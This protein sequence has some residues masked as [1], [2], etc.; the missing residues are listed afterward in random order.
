MRIGKRPVA[1]LFV[2]LCTMS[3]AVTAAAQRSPTA[4]A[5]MELRNAH[6]A[7]TS[8]VR[9]SSQRTSLTG[10]DRALTKLEDRW[11]QANGPE[12]DSGYVAVLRFNATL[13]RRA[14]V[15]PDSGQVILQYVEE[16]LTYKAAEI[17][18]GLGWTVPS[19]RNG[20][21]ITVKVKRNG[22]I[23]G[24]YLVRANPR[25]W[26][27][28]NPLFPFP[29][30]APTKLPLPAGNYIMWIVRTQTGQIVQT[31]ELPISSLYDPNI[32]FV[33]P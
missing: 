5:L 8:I 3:G 26:G 13:I 25:M 2:M 31:R 30:E 33:V 20:I 16:D 19:T 1:W 23:V 14:A 7:A 12:L 29:N 27:T 6:T 17:P 21:E 28:D 24:G 4:A 18:T 10:I 9:D 11:V 32:D 15:N 22:Q